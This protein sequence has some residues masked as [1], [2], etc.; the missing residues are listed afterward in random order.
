MDVF[1]VDGSQKCFADIILENMT[2]G[3]T[4]SVASYG[5]GVKQVKR[6]IHSFEQVLLVADT[7][8][9]QLNAE[10]YNTVVEMSNDIPQFTFKPI[11]THAKLA[12]IDNEK[13]IFTSAN[14][15]ANQRMES[16][17][18]GF[19]NEVSGIEKLKQTMG[20]PGGI[21]KKPCLSDIDPDFE[22]ASTPEFD[23]TKV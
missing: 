6:L 16:Y 18:V 14:L 5:F 19:F 7:S 2:T 8:H 22:F 1:F 15:S 23:C 21:F 17:M 11:K 12:L 13:I 4:C 10:A 3:K 9:S 20:D